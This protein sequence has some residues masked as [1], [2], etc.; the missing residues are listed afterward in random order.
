MVKTFAAV[1]RRWRVAVLE[2][3]GAALLIACAAEFDPRAGIGV[4]GVA[5]LLK[6]FEYDLRDQPPE[7]RR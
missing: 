5:V 7:R 4:A 6:S 1:A 2:L 3:I